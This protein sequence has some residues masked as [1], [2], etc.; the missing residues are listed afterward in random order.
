MGMKDHT[1]IGM[2]NS[3]SLFSKSLGG[4]RGTVQD[5]EMRG[6]HKNNS[7]NSL[8][9]FSIDVLCRMLSIQLHKLI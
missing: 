3:K 6:Q 5:L 7:S 1:G 4:G 9:L 2:I 8:H